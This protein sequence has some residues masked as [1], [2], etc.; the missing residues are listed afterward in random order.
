MAKV[1]DNILTSGLRGKIGSLVFRVVR[2]ETCV[3]AAPRKPDKRKESA[4][5]QHNR[6]T[7][8]M[9]S[10]W[11][12]AILRDSEKIE[13][14]RQRAKTWGLTNAYTAAMKDYM[15]CPHAHAD[16]SKSASP[17]VA[18]K[19]S[20]AMQ[21]DTVRK[22]ECLPPSSSRKLTEHASPFHKSALQ[23]R[24]DHPVPLVVAPAGLLRDGYIV[25]PGR[26]Y[27]LFLWPREEN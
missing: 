13:Y 14:Y 23:L 11:A 26:L 20:K 27:S 21:D 19:P 10:Q 17:T 18:A 15:R 16:S 7:F 22:A 4:R 1:I 25:R 6:A 5:Q 2:G 12:K 9:A 3:S 24:N 8:R